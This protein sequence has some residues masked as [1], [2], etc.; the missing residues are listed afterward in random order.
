MYDAPLPAYTVTAALHLFL[1]CDVSSAVWLKL[2]W[3]LDCLFILPPNLFVHWEC[4]HEGESDKKVKKGK[5]IIW[6]AT[7]WVLWNTRNEKVFNDVNVEVDAIVEEVKVLAWKWVMS[8]L[9]IPVLVFV[10][11][12]VQ[13]FFSA[14]ACVAEIGAA[15]ICWS[16]SVL[17]GGWAVSGFLVLLCLLVVR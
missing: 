9:C 7:I 14:I 12:E 17:I 15:S 11:A 5:G 3:W 2:M 1:H 4:W 8:K 10:S 16:V 6:L 13:Q